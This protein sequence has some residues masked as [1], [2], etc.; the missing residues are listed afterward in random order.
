MSKTL[1]I[2]AGH[3][4][5]QLAASLRK[6]GDEGQIT[7]VS[8]EADI[9]YHKPPLSKSFMQSPEEAL[10]PLRAEAFYEAHRISLM[11]GRQAVGIDSQ[12]KLVTFNDGGDETYDNLVL[13][14]GTRARQLTCPGHDLD[15]VFSIRTATDA[16]DLREQITDPKDVVII[17]GG[18]IGL[19]GAAMLAKLGHR[20]TVL[21]VG[22]RLLG[23]A[24]CSEAAEAVAS[25]LK[26]L[27]VH[28]LNDVGVDCLKGEDG[29]VCSV[30]T[31]EG[32]ELRAQL[33][34]VGIGAI[35][36]TALAEKAG[37]EIENGI[38]VDGNM[39]SSEASIF[40]IGDCVSYPQAHLQTRFRLESVQN[41]VEQ[42]DHL[43]LFLTNQTTEPYSRLPWFWSDIGSLKLQIAGM[44]IGETKRFPVKRDGK[45]A[46]VYHFQD[47][48][49]V[50]V[51]TINSSGEH[52]LARKMISTG[53]S[54]KA[55][56]EVL[57]HL[58]NLKQSFLK[59]MQRQ[60]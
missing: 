58:P 10:Q 42:A 29:K 32:D 39:C 50:S 40:A 53:F 52:M 5:V 22:P 16:R 3:G 38:K 26:E 47:D 1:I 7:L 17:G 21:E 15:G 12:R 6:H 2:G 55:D 34:I 4:G 60:E 43:A 37:L 24:V 46:S 31:S 48:K 20:V 19:E 36:Q 23:R 57:S 45:L 11:L 33:V 49:L 13:A 30:V 18:F 59:S 54:P 27:G 35:P 14:T 9:P 56:L 8:N 41:A 44:A 25:E 51:E 28:V